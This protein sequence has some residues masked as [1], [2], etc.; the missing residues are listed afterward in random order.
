MWWTMITFGGICLWVVSEWLYVRLST[1]GFRPEL[2]LVLLWLVLVLAATTLASWPL[3]KA[4]EHRQFA[5][6]W[7]TAVIMGGFGG[8]IVLWRAVVLAVELAGF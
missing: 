2:T 8:A 7:V 1:M 3:S 6:M 5:S 4:G